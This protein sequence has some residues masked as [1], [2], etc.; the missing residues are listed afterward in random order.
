V[1]VEEL[2]EAATLQVL[3]RLRPSLER[4]HKI[5]ISSRALESA[6]ALTQRHLPHLRLPDKAI[7]VL[8][9]ACARRR[10]QLMARAEGQP[11][12]GLPQEEKLTPHDVRK[13]VSQVAGIPLEELTE[14]ER[15]HL[16]DLERNIRKRLLGQDEAVGKVVATVKKSRAGMADP[17][18]PDA[19]MLFL[20]PSGVGKTQLAKLLA[21]NLFGSRTHLITFDMSEYVEEHAVARLLGA[22]PGYV[23]HGEEGRLTQAVQN[24]PFS[25]LLFDEIEKAHPRIFDIFLPIFDE[26]R[27]KDSRGREANFKNC[28]I[29]LTSN[30]GAELLAESTAPQSRKSLLEVL[31]GHFRPEFI[32]R[33][34]E[35]VPFYPLLAEDIRSILRLELKLIKERLEGKK[36]QLKIY[37]QAYETLAREGYTPDMGARELRRVVDQRVTVP[38]SEMILDGALQAGDVVEVFMDADRLTVR[39]GERAAAPVQEVTR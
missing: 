31:R 8:D 16:N 24:A 35:I 3:Q 7:D 27:L 22:P 39:R 29:I 12:A 14:R 32:N 23:G 38:I 9:Q 28:I 36:M 11:A 15:M 34:D 18:R 13:V 19:V 6:V 21:E 26:G 4:H 5:R 25:I 10:L 2:T 1:R 30:I 20:G 37:Q 33:I 17:N